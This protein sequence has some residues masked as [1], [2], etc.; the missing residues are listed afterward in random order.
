MSD[1]LLEEVVLRPA[2]RKVQI[3]DLVEVELIA[4]DGAVERLTFDI[5]PDARAD[6]AAGFLAAG[7]P[8][9]RAILGRPVGATV[10]YPV[11]DV[12][13]VRILAAQASARVPP[14]DQTA[15][16]LSTIQKAVERAEREEMAR[17]ALTVDVKWGAYDPGALEAD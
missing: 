13:A 3:G 8:L 6:F 1:P 16:R 2:A 9:A 5:V 7:T 12:V 15:A 17:L 14:S 11:G 4:A 10:S